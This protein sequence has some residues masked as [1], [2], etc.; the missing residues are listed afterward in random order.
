MAGS[1]DKP[2]DL[3][4]FDGAQRFLRNYDR[5]MNLLKLAVGF[6][7]Q[8]PEI[9]ASVAG[10]LRRAVVVFVHAAFEDG[11]RAVCRERL[12]MSDKTVLDDIPWVGGKDGQRFPLG[13]L[14][15]YRGKSVNEVIA[16]SV[17]AHLA[18]QSFSSIEQVVETL[19]VLGIDKRP[20]EQYFPGLN[21]MMQRRH[22]IVHE[23]DV[24]AP[25]GGGVGDVSEIDKGEVLLWVIV[26]GAFYA[27][28]RVTL[29]GED[30]MSPLLRLKK[31]WTGDF[32]PS[33]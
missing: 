20:F 25:E 4:A 1:G 7:N 11:L 5:L 18:R 28:L 23:A 3:A 14:S 30:W 19:R 33:T 9:A 17:E 24:V 2:L 32:G 15:E 13:V 22:R 10:D 21:R 12:G 26:V 31:A 6:G 8:Q 27:D 29:H 16:A